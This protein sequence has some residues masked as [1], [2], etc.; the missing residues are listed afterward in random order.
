MQQFKCRGWTC[1]GHHF[2]SALFEPYLDSVCNQGKKCHQFQLIWTNLHALLPQK[3][4]THIVHSLVLFTCEKQK[5]VGNLS[6]V[7]WYPLERQCS[8]LQQQIQWS[9]TN[10]FFIRI[11]LHC[12][13]WSEC[14]TL[15]ANSAAGINK[16]KNVAEE[17]NK[18]ENAA[19]EIN[20]QANA[21][22][23]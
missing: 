9:E 14:I 2:S 16:Q 17:I 5:A 4:C 7:H 12:T 15:G 19:V 20:K 1:A 18:Q 23:S 6:T 10:I 8:G 3:Q 11:F 21:G 22:D 13:N